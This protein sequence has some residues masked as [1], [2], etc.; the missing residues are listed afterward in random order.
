MLENPEKP[1]R[2]CAQFFGY[3]Q[4]WLSTLIH[5][6]A[7]RAHMAGLQGDANNVTLSDVPARLRGIADT[8]LDKLGESLDFVITEGVGARMDRDFVRDTAEMALKA[9]GYGSRGRD[10]TP[11]PEGG[12]TTIYADRLMIVQARERILD[13]GR[14]PDSPEPVLTIEHIPSGA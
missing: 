5:S 1:L 6:S 12:Q 10:S 14:A 9:L 13:R 3:T 8:A 11:A 2:E 4:S 7:F